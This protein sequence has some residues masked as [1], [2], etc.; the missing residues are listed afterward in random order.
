MRQIPTANYTPWEKSGAEAGCGRM[1]FGKQ[2]LQHIKHVGLAFKTAFA[3]RQCFLLGS[4]LS[5]F[6]CQLLQRGKENFLENYFLMWLS[7]N[8]HAE[9]E[10]T[11]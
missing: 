5:A 7:I 1:N 3:W 10:E 9:R 2:K 11:P 6:K 8:S 4:N